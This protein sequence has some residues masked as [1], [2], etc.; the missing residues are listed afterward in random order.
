MLQNCLSWNHLKELSTQ[1]TISIFSTCRTGSESMVKQL[2]ENGANVDTVGQ[3]GRTALMRAAE[4]GRKQS[5]K[6]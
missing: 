1:L 3:Y 6:E 2:I 4:K 5:F